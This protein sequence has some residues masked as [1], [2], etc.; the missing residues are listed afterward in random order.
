MA[1]IEKRKNKAGEVISYKII[2]YGGTDSNGDP[3]RRRMTWKPDY[4]MT[5]KQAEKAVQS[6]AAKFEQEISQGFRIDSGITFA[7]YAE[8]V[9]E[10][11]E[12]NGLQPRTLVRYRS[13]LP[14]IN[15]AIGHIA[16][17]KLGPQ[18]LNE[19]YKNLAEA[20]VRE[21]DERAIII[22]DLNRELK[23]RKLSK[24][25]LATITDMA[26]S[27]LRGAFN[28]DP[29][30]VST[31]ERIAHGLKMDPKIV[32]RIEKSGK[33]LSSKT[34]LEH[35]RLISSVLHQAEKEMYVMYNAA[36]RATPPK[37]KKKKPDYYQP[38]E[39]NKIIRALD[40]AP[41]KWKTITYIL[42][43]TG[44]RRG[45]AM[46]LKW[47]SIDLDN[48]IFTIERALLYTP[49]TGIFEGPPKNG[50][51]RTI[52]FAPETSAML[53]SWKKEQEHMRQAAGPLWTETGYVF[54]KATGEP[55]APD[56]IT[57]W[58]DTFSKKNDLPHIHPHAFRHTV[59]STMIADGIDLVTA[60]SELGHADATTTAKI[61]AHQIAEAKA[62][63]AEVRSN[64]FAR[65]R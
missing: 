23:K 49:E 10:M 27:T 6:I 56:S 53:K 21:G 40:T 52:R 28:G 61:Y 31:A 15:E 2:V 32:F 36:E 7:E 62:K 13:M 9:L 55:M 18:H 5:E 58:L 39:L 20:S 30:F 60:A 37:A 64:V 45:E 14:R 38:E 44:C 50:E 19:L 26:P 63:A 34:I 65:A 11:K 59:A 48:N 3:I 54:T 1:S 35:H 46:G 57:Q 42:I 25:K 8:M 41:L 22:I 33:P 51:S 4:G 29:V 17:S 47:E 16:L 43:D 12:R 24:N